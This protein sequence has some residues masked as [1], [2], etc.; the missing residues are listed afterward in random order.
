MLQNLKQSFYTPLCLNC[1]SF[2]VCDHLLCETCFLAF[3]KNLS[4]TDNRHAEFKHFFLIDWTPGESDLISEMVYRLKSD[5]SVK[6]WRYYAEVVAHSL[7]DQEDLEVFD[8]IVS[9][10]GS[11]ADSVHAWL[12]AKNLS[13][14]LGLPVLNILTKSALD[15]AQKSKSAAERK[16]A[17]LEN[18][19]QV[20][21]QFTRAE[22]SNL[23]LIYVDDIMTTGE[24]F[25]RCQQA[26]GAVEKSILITMF[27][28][29]RARQT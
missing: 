11:R 9:L 17:S 16:S 23:K 18:T 4:L 8:A 25:K 14:A 21:E 3:F 6:A 13:K 15:R 7:A 24:T 22:L 1:G 27:Y 5:R 19:I 12:F 29:P 2:F 20:D 26:L 28:R 10:P